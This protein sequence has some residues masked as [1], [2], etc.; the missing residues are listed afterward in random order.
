VNLRR[1]TRKKV[2]DQIRKRTR[3]RGPSAP[4]APKGRLSGSPYKNPLNRL[5]RK[6]SKKDYIKYSI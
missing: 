4:G 2:R 3:E 6:P 1:G 5:Y